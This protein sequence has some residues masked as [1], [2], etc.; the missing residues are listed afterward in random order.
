VQRLSYLDVLNP[1]EMQYARE[2]IRDLGVATRWIEAFDPPRDFKLV[3]PTLK[4]GQQVS[5]EL[6]EIAKRG[7]EKSTRYRAKCDILISKAQ[8]ALR[9]G[10]GMEHSEAYLQ[11]FDARMKP[12]Y[13]FQAFDRDAVQAV[14]AFQEAAKK[15]LPE[16]TK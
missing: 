16:K 13:E 5:S 10:E 2:M 1:G 7:S 9:T 12:L 6:I 11:E 3:L 4:R 15:W 14:S 8:Q